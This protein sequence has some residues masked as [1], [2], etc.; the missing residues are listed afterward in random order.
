MA[1]HPAVGP[2]ALRVRATALGMV[3]GAD[4]CGPVELEIGETGAM[5]LPDDAAPV[6]AVRLPYDTL[7]GVSATGDTLTVFAAGGDV[8]ELSGAP[9][10]AAAAREIAQRACSLPEL[11]RPLRGLG[12]HRAQP[13]ADHDQFYRAL[14]VARRDAERTGDPARRIAA[15]DGAALRSAMRRVLSDFAGAHHPRYAPDRRALHAELEE[16]ADGLFRALDDVSARADA[17]GAAG[18]DSRLARWRE[19]TAAV[20]RVFDEADRCWLLVL[21]VLAR[22]PVRRRSS[23][24]R[25]LRLG[26]VV[27]LALPATARAQTRVTV[28]VTG[29]R[30]DSL[31]AKGFDVVGEHRGLATVVVDSAARARLAAMGLATRELRPVAALRA[32]LPGDAVVAT[33][34]YRPFDDPARG[35][36]WWID[37]LAAANPLVH[38]DSIGTSLEGRPILAVKVGAADDSPSR[39]N[40]IFL[41]T[42]HAREWAAT[43]MALRLIRHLSARPAPSGRVASLVA[44]RDVWIVPV[45]NPDGYQYTF[46]TSR[47]WRKNRRPNTDGTFGV[48]LN[49]NHAEHWGFDDAGSSPL[50]A[51][52]VYRGPS[53]ASELETQAIERLHALHPPVTSV[54]YHTYTG[55]ILFPP[56]YLYGALPGDLGI[57]RAIAGTDERPSVRDNLPGALRG[58]YRPEP[59]WNLYTTNGEYNDW[60]YA[61]YGTISFTPELT[62]GFE[63]E[64]YYGFEFPDDEGRLETVF[65]DNLPFALDVLESAADPLG[66]A[67]VNTGRRSERISIES[68]SPHI[69]ARVPAALPAPVLIAGGPV[70]YGYDTVGAGRYTRRVVSLPIARPPRISITAGSERADYDLL[71]VGGA[72]AGDAGWT[73]AGFAPTSD[74]KVAGD[75]SWFASGGTLRSPI[76]RVP[77]D[78][79]TLSVVYW[80]RYTGNG[81]SMEPHGELRLSRDSGRTFITESRVSGAAP[82]FYPEQATMAQVAGRFVQVEL[83]AV[84]LPWWVDE[85]AIVAHSSPPVTL[86][87]VSALVPSENPVRGEVVRLQWP[88]TAA[89]DVLVYDFAGRLVWRERVNAGTTFAEWNVAASN[90]RNGVYLAVARAGRD[91]RRVK[92]FILRGGAR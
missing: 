63:G 38:V 68:V 22:S 83:E 2:V 89:G 55:L 31:L 43:E 58:Y 20:R 44:S 71:A 86:P 33:T 15:F 88:F 35:V 62:S 77:F 39:P 29:A 25:L 73:V 54:S 16:V 72:E 24:Q 53:A 9:R 64:S 90:P 67:S 52:E 51:S 48:D 5:V 78:A 37:S 91:T 45:V 42:Y 46:T 28:E 41:A 26:A 6:R 61:R 21:P 87:I 49:R 27:L 79:D 17:V 80:T 60:A 34:V 23:W 84:G 10:L 32:R 82:A 70:V 69:R 8:L 14:L 7:E 19:W 66:F 56:G 76:V 40:V 30:A 11:T 65:Q 3:R 57:Y 85:I 12:S 59:S 92:L 74:Q 18:D 81:F 47:L 50:P 36:R 4:L 1:E 75:N 13:G